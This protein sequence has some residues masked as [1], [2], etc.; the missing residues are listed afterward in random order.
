[1]HCLQLCGS[2]KPY[3]GR[4]SRS[5]PPVAVPTEAQLNAASIKAPDAPPTGDARFGVTVPE[6]FLA[7]PPAPEELVEQAART[8]GWLFEGRDGTYDIVVPTD[9]ERTQAVSVDLTRR[10]HQGRRLLV[11]SSYCGPATRKN[12]LP[13]LRLNA[14]LGDIAFGAV[15]VDDQELAA[16]SG[17]VPV[18]YATQTDVA[19]LIARVASYADRAESKLIGVDQY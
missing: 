6:A 1:M 16:L 8:R 13:L 14:R 18:D 12:A 2:V 10:D 5:V 17:S 7:T 15:T 3:F 19:E 11:C 9:L 4:S